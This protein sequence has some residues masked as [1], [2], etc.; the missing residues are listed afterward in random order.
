IFSTA[1]IAQSVGPAWRR[2]PAE[3]ERRTERLLDLSRSALAEMRSLLFELRPP[4]GDQA[5]EP[6]VVPGLVR[7]QRDGLSAALR[8]YVA[9]L[10]AEGLSIDVESA[11]YEPQPAPY[12]EALYRIAQEAL[13]NVVKHSKA[14]QA[15]VRLTVDRTAV[16]LT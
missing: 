12:E 14:G 10:V 16:R 7:A 15:T 5:S 1:L 8:E 11:G 4:E 6:E 2:D 13:N 9:G 3:G